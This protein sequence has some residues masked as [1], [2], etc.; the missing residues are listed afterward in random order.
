M[1]PRFAVLESD[2]EFDEDFLAPL[3]RKQTLEATGAGL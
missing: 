3:I 1:H 2:F